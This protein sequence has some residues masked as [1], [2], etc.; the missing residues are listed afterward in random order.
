MT[1]ATSGRMIRIGLA[2]LAFEAGLIAVHAL[3]FPLY[4][5]EEFLLGRGWVQMLPP[6]N[7]H[8]TRDLGALYLGFFVVLTFA[9]VKLTRD[10]VNGAVLGFLVATV[11]HMVFHGLHTD[12]A[13]QLLDK[14]LQ[15]GL[16]ALTVGACVAILWLSR[17][18]FAAVEADQR[19]PAVQ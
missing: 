10:V 11:P 8:I 9:A 17:R 19:A 2:L 18:H 13:P 12:D 1:T 6:Y 3:F 4:F 15:P 14:I 7:E 16:L 5:Y